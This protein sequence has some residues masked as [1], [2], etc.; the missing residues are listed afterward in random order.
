MSPPSTARQLLASQ[1]RSLCDSPNPPP[2]SP[3]SRFCSA[4]FPHNLSPKPVIQRPVLL[5]SPEHLS[6]AFAFGSSCRTGGCHCRMFPGLGEEG[7]Y[8]LPPA[9]PTHEKET[10][11]AK[12]ALALGEVGEGKNHQIQMCLTCRKARS[13]TTSTLIQS[14]ALWVNYAERNMWS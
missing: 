5:G 10:G 9:H 3:P 12:S 13:R 14:R 4:S 7:Q 11:G 1:S 2:H 8:L 6:L